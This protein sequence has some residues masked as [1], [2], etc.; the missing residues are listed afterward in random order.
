MSY[1]GGDG[2]TYLDYDIKGKSYWEQLFGNCGAAYL[3]AGIG[4]GLYGGVAAVKVS[5]STK[6]RVRSNAFLNGFSLQGA[7][8]GNAVAT[9]ALMYTSF[10]NLYETYEVEAQLGGHPAVNSVLGAASTGLL[11]KCTAGAR[12]ML[13][14]GALGGLGM[15]LYEV[16]SQQY[17]EAMFGSRRGGF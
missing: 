11:Y 8:G 16:G 4:G 7:K 1:A 13:V 9:V 10:K 3:V 6:A 12:P 15:G 5:P 17:S 2:P 14:A